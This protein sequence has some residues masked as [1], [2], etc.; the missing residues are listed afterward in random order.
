M[1]G[2]T[3]GELEILQH[4]LRISQFTPVQELDADDGFIILFLHVT[5]NSHIAIRHIDPVYG[6]HYAITYTEDPA[7][8]LH[9]LFQVVRRVDEIPYCLVQCIGR[10]SATLPKRR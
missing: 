5:Y 9:F 10:H 4:F 6:L 1:D 3:V 8:A 7:T 2:R